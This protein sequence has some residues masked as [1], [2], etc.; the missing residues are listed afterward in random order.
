LDKSSSLG[1][2]GSK[3]KSPGRV[4]ASLLLRR[5]SEER[6]PRKRTSG[7][8][9]REKTP[10]RSRGKEKRGEETPEEKN[11]R[12][13]LRDSGNSGKP[14]VSERNKM[15]EHILSPVGFKL[16]RDHL[17]TKFCEENVDFVSMV[18]S[19]SSPSLPFPTLPSVPFLPPPFFLPFLSFPSSFLSFLPFL[20]FLLS[21]YLSILFLPSIPSSSFVPFSPLRSSS[22][23]VCPFLPPSSL[24][25]SLPLPSLLLPLT[26]HQVEKWKV[27]T[28]ETKTDI[29]LA[30]YKRFLQPGSTSGI[31]LSPNWERKTVW[32][33]EEGGK[34]EKRER[35]RREEGESE[36]RRE[37]EGEKKKRGGEEGGKRE[38]RERKGRGGRKREGRGREEGRRTRITH[39]SPVPRRVLEEWLEP[40]QEEVIDLLLGALQDSEERMEE[41][42]KKGE[43]GGRGREEGGE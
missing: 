16:F 23:R 1:S 38:K 39:V 29:G 40:I 35:K 30:I 31:C 36:E 20:L 13:I 32:E 19:P 41:G 18:G 11:S 4:P 26:K 33:R 43:E 25:S 17:Q 6:A 10:G 22:L 21:S 15:M 27:A 28:G 34:R 2:L 12:E 24:P 5:G 7:W 42:E 9:R 3:D 8:E 14:R 37:E